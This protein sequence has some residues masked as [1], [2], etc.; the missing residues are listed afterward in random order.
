MVE[1]YLSINLGD[2]V[3]MKKPHACDGKNKKFEI[4]R[5]GADVKIKCCNCGHVIMLDRDAFNLKV[6]KLLESKN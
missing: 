3:E 5:V 2:I 4:V 6:R 1:K